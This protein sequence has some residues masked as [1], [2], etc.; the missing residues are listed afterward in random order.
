[1][2]ALVYWCNI[3]EIGELIVLLFDT[4]ATKNAY[5]FVVKN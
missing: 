4:A 1:M 5:S 3:G 2:S